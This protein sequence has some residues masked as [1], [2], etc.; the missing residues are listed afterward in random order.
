MKGRETALYTH[1]RTNTHEYSV[2]KVGD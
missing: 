2:K 1:A